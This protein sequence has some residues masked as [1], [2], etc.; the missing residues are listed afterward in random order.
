VDVQT[1]V[2]DQAGTVSSQTMD[3]AGQV[4]VFKTRVSQLRAVRVGV[5]GQMQSLVT[6]LQNIAQSKAQLLSMFQMEAAHLVPALAVRDVYLMVRAYSAPP[7]VMQL[8]SVAYQGAYSQSCALYDA[9]TAQF[10]KLKNF[11]DAGAQ[12]EQ[13]L[14]TQYG[15]FAAQYPGQVPTVDQI[16]ADVQALSTIPTVDEGTVVA[17]QS[18]VLDQFRPETAAL[19]VGQAVSMEN[20]YS[21]AAVNE[22]LTQSM[23]APDGGDTTTQTPAQAALSSPNFPVPSVG[24]SP[25][26]LSKWQMILA[27]IGTLYVL[28]R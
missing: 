7:Q 14:L 9:R 4:S 8:W 13:D 10:N 26:Q 24:A 15:I 28:L 27:A 22:Q 23:V 3:L 20:N 11:A 19:I 16:T 2:S 5:I 6:Q 17:R 21:S 18:D 12:A 1:Q 25:I